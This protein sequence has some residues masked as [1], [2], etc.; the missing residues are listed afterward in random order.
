MTRHISYKVIY[1][2]QY[3]VRQQSYGSFKASYALP[4]EVKREDVKAT[5]RSGIL[6]VCMPKAEVTEEHKVTVEAKD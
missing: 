1:L 4:A 2:Q 5:Y 6:V 3:H